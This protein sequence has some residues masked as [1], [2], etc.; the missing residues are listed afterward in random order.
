MQCN[1]PAGRLHAIFQAL[2]P[3]AGHLKRAQ[4][5]QIL[6]I[7]ESWPAVL[8]AISDVSKEVDLLD[9]A[10]DEFKPNQQKYNLFQKNLK[11]VRAIADSFV[12]D[13]VS[14]AITLRINAGGLTSLGYMAVDLPQEETT[15]KSEIDQLR[16]MIFELQKEIEASTEI[17]KQVREW[18][19]DIVRIL[20]DS[21]DRY[22]IRG[23]RGMR[24]FLAQALGELYIEK[25]T[26]EK[27][28]KTKPSI[29]AR[30]GPCLDLMI[31]I[32]TLVEKIGPAL[33][34]GQRLLGL[35][36]QGVTNNS[37]PAIPADVG[38]PPDSPE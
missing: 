7:S 36:D 3:K 6:E 20:R 24:D 10:I 22:A 12:V 27:V 34:F 15:P 28:V 23:G 11:D 32:V 4:F 38:M 13:M 33:S 14:D 19:L 25:K 16:A 29:W 21:L 37:L 31:K 1:N 8:G 30:L 17:S 9:A 18:L 2:E 35:T 5:C 26:I